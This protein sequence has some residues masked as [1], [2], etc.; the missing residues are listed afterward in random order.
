M[1]RNE[2]GNREKTVEKQAKYN[3]NYL[4][5]EIINTNDKNHEEFLKLKI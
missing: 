2:I 3:D 5:K 1:Y 4:D